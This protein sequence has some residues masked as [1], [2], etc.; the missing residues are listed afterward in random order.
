[1]RLRRAFPT[2]TDGYYT[3]IGAATP[4]NHSVTKFFYDQGWSGINVEPMLD[5]YRLLEV[6]RPRDLNLNCGVSDKEGSLTLHEATGS[7]GRSTFEIE[8]CEGWKAYDGQEFVSREVPVVTLSQ[9]CEKHVDRTIDF[10]KIDVEGHEHFVVQGMDFRRWRPIVIVLEGSPERWEH[11]LTS[12]D[13]LF[14]AEDGI[15]RYYVRTEDRHLIPKLA[16]P[17][18]ILDDYK[19][20]E[21]EQL[22]RELRAQN[23]ALLEQLS[24]YEDLGQRSAALAIRARKIAHRVPGARRLIRWIAP[25]S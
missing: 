14:A 12:A 19:L 15:N 3:D 10:L 24:H 1:M 23:E 4:I 20:F 2:K 25:V 18:S 22:V 21:H 8:A 9:I 7:I 17:I 5:F 11:L 6:D 13:Y 16:A